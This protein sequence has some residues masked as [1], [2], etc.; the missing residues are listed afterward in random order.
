MIVRSFSKCG[1]SLPIDGSQDDQIN[2]TGME[3]YEVGSADRNTDAS[4]SEASYVATD[5]DA[6]DP[7]ADL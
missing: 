1:I 2:I 7:F 3:D 4:D 6:E 5:D